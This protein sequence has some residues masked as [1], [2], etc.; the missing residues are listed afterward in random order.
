DPIAWQDLRRRIDTLAGLRQRKI[1]R[2]GLMGKLNYHARR[3]G[4]ILN[5]E[6]AALE[7]WQRLAGVVEK[8][9]ESGIPPSNPEI[10]ATL[11]PIIDNVPELDFAAGF[12]AALDEAD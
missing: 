5:D 10:R 8:L 7:E 4:D 12:R 11:L 1:D 2:R 9:V 3:A 6:A